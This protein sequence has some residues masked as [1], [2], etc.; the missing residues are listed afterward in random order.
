MRAVFSVHMN[1]KKTTVCPLFRA[2]VGIY[3][4]CNG[5]LTHNTPLTCHVHAFLCRGRRHGAEMDTYGGLGDRVECVWGGSL[6]EPAV[7]LRG[8]LTPAAAREVFDGYGVPG[9]TWVHTETLRMLGCGDGV[10]STGSAAVC[11]AQGICLTSCLV[12]A[13]AG[14]AA[15]V[16]AGV[17][18]TTD[19]L[20]YPPLVR[21][22]VVP[23]HVWGEARRLLGNGTQRRP[24]VGVDDV[25]GHPGLARP[26][27]GEAVLQMVSRAALAGPIRHA[28]RTLS[29]VQWLQ[30]VFAAAPICGAPS[31]RSAPSAPSE[32]TRY[33]V[34]RFL[35]CNGARARDAELVR[36]MLRN[37]HCTNPV[38]VAGQEDVW[39]RVWQHR[40]IVAALVGCPGQYLAALCAAL[41]CFL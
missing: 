14:G 27:A 2:G 11:E 12:R 24:R 22:Y 15:P 7:V 6:G 41:E 4:S 33:R 36:N 9:G 3:F 38:A 40:D 34:S 5:K 18:I 23:A 30:C 17:L 21:C 10:P 32:G 26:G 25:F 31:A 20:L 28:L 29:D 1:Q 13:C 19:V 8:A 39:R 16:H 37:R 35:Y